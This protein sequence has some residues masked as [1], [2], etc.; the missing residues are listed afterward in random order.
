[1]RCDSGWVVKLR[2]R[3]APGFPSIFLDFVDGADRAAGILPP[4]PSLKALAALAHRARAR[5]DEHGPLWEEV[6]ARSLALEP[7]P[8]ARRGLERLSGGASVAVVAIHKPA[9]FGGLLSDLTKTM[10]AVKL[11][12]FLTRSG[13]HALPVCVLV[14]E[15]EG[16][17]PEEELGFVDARGNFQA[18]G[19]AMDLRVEGLPRPEWTVSRAAG[20]WLDRM[21][22]SV[23]SRASVAP[24]WDTARRSHREG[25]PVKKAW[26]DFMQAVF[27]QDTLVTLDFDHLSQAGVRAAVGD[28]FGAEM[29]SALAEWSAR[30]RRAGYSFSPGWRLA[31]GADG[32]MLPDGMV[33]PLLTVLLLPAVAAVADACEL[34]RWSAL[35]ALCRN[36]RRD[37]PRIWP[38]ASFTAV[39][40]RSRRLL[41]RYGIP[42]DLLY[43]GVAPLLRR[44]LP[45][46]GADEVLRGISRLQDAAE[47]R[48]RT[49]SGFLGPEAAATAGV[50]RRLARIHYQLEKLAERSRVHRARRAEILEDRFRRLCT[51]LAPEG[52]L[53][54]S[55]LAALQVLAEGAEGIVQRLSEGMDITSWQHQYL[56]LD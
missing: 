46:Q 40:S 15:P 3:E 33:P 14:S 36:V 50:Q 12:A 51:R 28:G 11:A 42:P 18:C 21:S 27:Q 16:S 2:F 30:V 31:P 41:D 35:T 5:T 55:R 56:N 44:A 23:D 19:V 1:M 39:D 6:S 22:M 17:E 29:M 47:A 48:A 45:E 7:G 38:R 10:T 52:C 49:L 9:L 26:S 8:E 13:V 32:P 20:E 24:V 54:E 43:E 25:T 4:P 37:S 34:P 53:Q